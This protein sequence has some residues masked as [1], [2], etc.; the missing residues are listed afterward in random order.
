[1]AFTGEIPTSRHRHRARWCVVAATGLLA[2]ACFGQG[3]GDT[4]YVQRQSLPIRDGKRAYN[5]ILVTAMQNDPLTV[6]AIEGDWLKVKYGSGPQAVEGYVREDALTARPLSAAS[7][8]AGSGGN[9]TDVAGAAAG[10][11]LKPEENA[12]AGKAG[13]GSTLNASRY[14]AAKG[15]NPDPFYK[16]VVDSHSAVTDAVFDKFAADGKLGP[17]R[18]NSSP[19]T[20]TAPSVQ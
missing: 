7:T 18:S 5:R 8:A 14:A 20:S 10:R 13:P 17:K 12:A 1:M 6:T 9:A 2:A 15:L 19:A 16:M 4:L 3:V 11:S